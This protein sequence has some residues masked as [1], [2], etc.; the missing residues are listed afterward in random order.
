MGTFSTRNQLSAILLGVLSTKMLPIAASAEP[1]RQKYEL[2]TS[3]RMR[4]H[5]PAMTKTPPT[6][7]LMRIPYLLRSQLQGKANSG[8]AIVKRRAFI[9]TQSLEMRKVFSIVTFMLE[10]VCTGNE[11]T[12]AV[13]MYAAKITHWYF[14]YLYFYI[15]FY[16]CS[17]SIVSFVVYK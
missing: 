6:M 8:C 17:I 16:S 14:S 7:K 1:A 5:T 12:S 9:V 11:F 4:S 2:S 10:N 15:V 13:K 3:S